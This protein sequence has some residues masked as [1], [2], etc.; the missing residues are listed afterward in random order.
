MLNEKA[1][2]GKYLN[3]A[4][5][6]QFKNEMFRHYS[7]YKK[8]YEENCKKEKKILPLKFP[9]GEDKKRY[10]ENA[11]FLPEGLSDE[12]KIQLFERMFEILTSK[13]QIEI[14]ED[15]EKYMIFRLY[16]DML[17][18]CSDY[19]SSTPGMVT[20]AKFKAQEF[21][22]NSDYKSE[23]D[24]FGFGMF[25][26][27]D[28]ILCDLKMYK[29]ESCLWYYMSYLPFSSTKEDFLITEIVGK[30]LSFL[31]KNYKEIDKKE[32]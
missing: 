5:L 32:R 16:D 23:L 19:V 20:D 13:E 1:P 12:K 7:E 18:V 17:N 24:Y 29:P 25:D 14:K 27:G 28:R 9:E 11:T 22:Q 26:Y 21:A 15:I 30:D 10:I 3:F 6:T 31:G 4:L 2:F 8:T